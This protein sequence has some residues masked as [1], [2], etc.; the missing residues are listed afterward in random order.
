MIQTQDFK[1]MSGS[2]PIQLPSYLAIH[3]G[4]QNF[5]VPHFNRNYLTFPLALRSVILELTN[6]RLDGVNT[7]LADQ[8]RRIDEVNKM[9]FFPK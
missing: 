5:H 3:T 1:P 8:S 7:H 6:K 2:P 9:K 4:Y